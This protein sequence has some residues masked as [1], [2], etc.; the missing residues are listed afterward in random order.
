M[1]IVLTCSN[2]LFIFIYR[3]VKGKLDDK[4][5]TPAVPPV[6]PPTQTLPKQKPP[7][8]PEPGTPTGDNPLALQKLHFGTPNSG[9]ISPASSHSSQ[10]TPKGRGR[11]CGRPR[12]VA[13]PPTYE[14]F[15]VGAS[16]EEIQKYLKAKKTQRWRY[17]KL[18]GPEASEHRQK[19]NERVSQFYYKKKAAIGKDGTDDKQDDDE[20]AKELGRIR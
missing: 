17:E 18:S 4:P 12:K 10:I 19:E 6:P 15:P 7:Q 3:K 8:V 2:V 20:R 11:G 9:S 1:K 13:E 16:N 5:V 14:D